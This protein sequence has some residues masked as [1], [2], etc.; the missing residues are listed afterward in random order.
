ME[1][2]KM[3]INVSV[4]ENGVI[5][6]E[7]DMEGIEK[8]LVVLIS[9]VLKE[10]EKIKELFKTSIGFIESGLLD[11]IDTNEYREKTG[12]YKLI[13]NDEEMIVTKEFAID[14]AKKLKALLENNKDVTMKMT[15]G[16]KMQYIYLGEK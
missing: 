13:F 11:D 2:A 12:M 1:K 4:N 7:V 6:Q 15:N 9:A 3:N 16:E 10:N 8:D 5:R 14:N